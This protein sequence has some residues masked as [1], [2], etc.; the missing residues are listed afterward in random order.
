MI[1]LINWFSTY[2]VEI[3][4]FIIGFLVFAGLD[5]F[6]HGN[7]LCAFLNFGFAFLNYKCYCYSK[8]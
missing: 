4:W 7:D 6:A 8:S 2:N 5:D 3:T 1:K